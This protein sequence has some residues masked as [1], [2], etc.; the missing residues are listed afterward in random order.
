MRVLL[1]ACK[2]ALKSVSFL[3]MLAVCAVVIYIAS[4][5]GAAGNNPPAGVYG[6]GNSPAAQRVIDYLT[7]N[8]FVWYDD[9][10]Q[11]RRDVEVGQLDCAVILPDDLLQRMEREELEGCV[12]FLNSPLSFMPQLYQNQIAAAVFR[13]YAPYI[14][15]RALKDTVVP[16]E[17]VV[18][19]YEKLFEKGYVFSFELV[20]VD[21]V[22]VEAN[23]ERDLMMGAAA[24]LIFAIL[25]SAGVDGFQREM[26]FR[27][28][29]RKTLTRIALP[30]VL[31]R[32][33]FAAAVGGVALALA[34]AA[35]LI[36]PL[37]VYALVL[38]ALSVLLAA[39]LPDERDRYILLTVILILSLALCP[40]YVDLTLFSPLLQSAR[41]VL[42]PY[43]FYLAVNA[44]GMW[45]VVG[46]VGMMIACGTVLVRA[47]V[48]EKLRIR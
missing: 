2:R 46:V 7:T 4:L 38:S 20:N 29:L 16:R 14:C 19:E 22:P 15:G 47:R 11:M 3:V 35:E 8:G 17:E 18:A 37:A 34:G 33:A 1:F 10:E 36:L 13:E 31:V 39:V 9:T 42:P 41:S 25:M 32:A 30:G 21:G 45:L 24:L 48:I 27:L 43:W 44:P 26:I 40:I 12:E 23:S 28:G 5:E 6:M